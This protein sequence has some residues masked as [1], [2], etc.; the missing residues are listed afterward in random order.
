MVVVQFAQ[1]RSYRTSSVSPWPGIE[2]LFHGLPIAQ[3][4]MIFL[5]RYK[6]SFQR[7]PYGGRNFANR[8][9]TTEGLAIARRVFLDS[10]RQAS[11]NSRGWKQQQRLR[12]TLNSKRHSGDY[13]KEWQQIHNCLTVKHSP[14]IKTQW[15]YVSYP[16]ASHVV[17]SWSR[18]PFS[19]T[20]GPI[21]WSISTMSRCISKCW[22]K[23]CNLLSSNT[24]N[25]G[26]SC[27]M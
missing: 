13:G 7:K 15:T 10:S 6:Q 27:S 19:R 22:Q 8:S 26:K 5:E 18:I 4:Q 12:L 14:P 20:Y 1:S 2:R 16:T 25:P 21:G 24:T 3:T 23:K 11:V 9:G 17:D